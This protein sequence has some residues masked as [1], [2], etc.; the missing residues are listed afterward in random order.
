MIDRVLCK[1]R[2]QRDL[3]IKAG[4]YL[5]WELLI[6][7][8]R[9]SRQ[10]LWRHIPKGRCCVRVLSSATPPIRQ[11]VWR[12]E[13][14]EFDFLMTLK[15]KTPKESDV[16]RISWAGSWPSI[17]GIKLVKNSSEELT[18][19]LYQLQQKRIG[20]LRYWDES[21]TNLEQSNFL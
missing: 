11:V 18:K 19:Y 14:K 20:A 13:C 15:G 3:R 17:R 10:A 2:K 8:K 16:S 9:C 5:R 6:S 12:T 1:K 21:F 4:K 7:W